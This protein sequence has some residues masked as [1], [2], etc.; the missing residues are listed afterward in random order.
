M[1]TLYIYRD[2]DL[3]VLC[4]ELWISYLFDTLHWIVL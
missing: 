1:V 3:M 4:Y 2:G